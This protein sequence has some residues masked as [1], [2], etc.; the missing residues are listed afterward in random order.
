MADGFSARREATKIEQ[1][2]EKM[3]QPM[4]PIERADL[5][6]KLQAEVNSMTLKQLREVG[7][8]IEKETPH[9]DAMTGYM[10]DVTFD[11]DKNVVGFVFHRSQNSVSVRKS[12]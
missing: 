4:Y 10:N 9:M 11:D 7:L 12:N 3:E 8:L 5:Q 2:A 1:L 6:K